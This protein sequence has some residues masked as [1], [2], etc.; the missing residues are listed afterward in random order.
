MCHHFNNAAKLPAH[1]VAEYSLR[2]NQRTLFSELAT[3]SGDLGAW[4]LRTI[5]ALR[6]DGEGPG[7]S[8]EVFVAEWG[9]LP[10]WWKPSER[11]PKRQAFQRQTINARSETAHEK[12]TFRDAMRRRRCLIPC[13]EFFERGHYFR[14][15]GSERL[16]ADGADPEPIA[17][18]GLWE[19]WRDAPSSGE[20]VTLTTATLLTTEPNAEVRAVG[21]HRMPVLL[22]TPE[23][24]R[25]W[26][27]EGPS[28]GLLVPLADRSLV[29]RG[30]G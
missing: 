19:T 14:L 16:E 7:A 23:A 11:T 17:F 29:A 12:P 6:L 22:T 1:F 18:A 13:G 2:E 20:P 25:A 4:P 24:R 9:L 15:A 27:V 5:P 30:K 3:A 28:P 8:L 26:L 21:H 10:G